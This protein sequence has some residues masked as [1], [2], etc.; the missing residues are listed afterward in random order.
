MLAQFQHILNGCLAEQTSLI[1]ES[2]QPHIAYGLQLYP[3]SRCIECTRLRKDV[4][5]Q[6]AMYEDHRA[7]IIRMGMVNCICVE[8][9]WL[10]RFCIKIQKTECHGLQGHVR[11]T[12]TARVSQLVQRSMQFLDI[13][14]KF[15]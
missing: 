15:S 2:N 3:L 12:A 10:L 14:R 6:N 8:K 4:N 7:F 5:L 11:N 9:D 1:T 13:R